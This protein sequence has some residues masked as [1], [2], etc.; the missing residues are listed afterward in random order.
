M[1]QHV[2][3]GLE[4]A[5]DTPS[6]CQSIIASL[7]RGCWAMYSCGAQDTSSQQQ[8]TDSF[9]PPLCP[10]TIL[11]STRCPFSSSG[12]YILYHE[13]C[14]MYTSGAEDTP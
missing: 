2:K 9:Q 4:A 5:P 14:D 10:H 11:C 7:H 8:V 13:C 1:P 6:H 12:H 3:R